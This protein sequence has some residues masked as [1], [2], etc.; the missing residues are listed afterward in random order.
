VGIHLAPDFPPERSSVR[1]ARS[2]LE[3]VF[4]AEEVAGEGCDVCRLLLDELVANAILHGGGVVEVSVD[5]GDL[6]R[7]EV[8]NRGTDGVVEPI[9][10]ERGRPAAHFGLHL[11]DGLSTSWG[12]IRESDDTTVW[13]ELAA[14]AWIVESTVPTP[15]RGPADRVL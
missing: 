14:P 1:M 6:A 11:V 3:R 7:V 15:S 10:Y 2:W 9:P 5:V 4:E 12:V 8:T 13:F